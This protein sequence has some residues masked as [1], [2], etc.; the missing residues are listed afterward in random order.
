MIEIKDNIVR[1]PIIKVFPN[2]WNPNEQT[3][4]IYEKEK[5]SITKFGMLDPILVREIPEGY[6]I[7]DGEHRYNACL[8]LGLTEI[9]VNNMGVVSDS[10]AEQLTVIMNETKGTA[11][12][13]KLGDLMKRINFTVPTEELRD[14]MPFTD[15]EMN[16]FLD[17]N[18]IQWDSISSGNKTS[19]ESDKNEN[20]ENFRTIAFR[21]PESVAEQFEAQ[22]LRFKKILHPEDKPEDASPVMS[23]EAMIQHIAQIPDDQII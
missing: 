20:G 9:P 12:R 11:D 17:T 2:T 18:S 15:G 10:V 13:V 16:W 3:D 7:I 22:V 4:F 23:I 14:V 19:S 21:L 5:K 6:E 1:V 8:E